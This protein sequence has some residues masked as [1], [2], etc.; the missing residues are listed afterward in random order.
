MKNGPSKHSPFF[1]SLGYS[2]TGPSKLRH[3][4]GYKSINYGDNKQKI[5]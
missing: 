3:K 2:N 5:C 4:N 1:L